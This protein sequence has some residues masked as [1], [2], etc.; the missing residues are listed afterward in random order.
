[1]S[2][3]KSISTERLLRRYLSGDVGPKE[4]AELH[5]RAR[6]DHALA[7]V[8]AGIDA[9]PEEDHAAAIERIRAKL[10]R[11]EAKVRTL[12]YAWRRL[13]VAVTL[14]AAFAGILWYLPL[15]QT[16]DGAT[17]MEIP[18]DELTE[19]RQE[20]SADMSATEGPEQ[21]IESDL[22]SAREA[23]T[24]DAEEM[25]STSIPADPAYPGS[26]QSR[27]SANSRTEQSDLNISEEPQ[28]P[29]LAARSKVD[30]IRPESALSPAVVP[31]DET[32]EMAARSRRQFEPTEANTIQAEDAVADAPISMMD[33]SD[34]Q[35]LL[36]ES[37]NTVLIEG[38]V[39]GP[40]GELIPNATVRTSTL[41]L[42][43]ITNGFG[44]FSF[45]S[46]QSVSSIIIEA[47]GYESSEFRLPQDE[48]SRQSRVQSAPDAAISP[49]LTRKLSREEAFSRGLRQG[50]PGTVD[51]PLYTLEPKSK[52]ETDPGN[53]SDF[54][55][56]EPI[57]SIEGGMQ[58]FRRKIIDEKPSAVGSGRVRV[59][60][61]VAPSG[62]VINLRTRGGNRELRHYV[63]DYLKNK[64]RWTMI[65]GNEAVDLNFELRF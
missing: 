30:Q 5:Q 22:P 35:N 63:E 50:D 56:Q 29:A 33:E 34:L 24:S 62:R 4:E 15:N 41:P 16:E 51:A 46:D 19:T 39:T 54:S 42:G 9:R 20:S 48:S 6:Q 12:P 45:E 11:R 2:K 40:E 23:T 43:E 13:A 38:F 3:L 14:L 37:P 65:Q 36:A 64:T 28:A 21:M 7:E 8:L 25:T 60:L 52:V 47:P 32:E 26:P 57:V 17:A 44:F 27:L 18:T 49:R 1:M 10:P 61:S 59:S 53:A 58:A 31:A 55:T